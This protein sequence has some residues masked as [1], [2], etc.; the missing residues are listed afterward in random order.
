MGKLLV[1]VLATCA[2]LWAVGHF[3]G[4]HRLAS[5]AF[6]VPGTEHTPTFG[7]TWTMMVGACVGYGVYRI[8]KS[9]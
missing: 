8:V 5:V 2:A 3:V 7:I 1:I 6:T 4:W 9:K